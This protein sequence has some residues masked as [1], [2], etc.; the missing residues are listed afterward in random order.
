MWQTI[1]DFLGPVPAP[2]FILIFVAGLCVSLIACAPTQFV[3]RGER[4][5]RRLL[6]R[7]RNVKNARQ[8]TV[9]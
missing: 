4:V 7:R 9:F 2:I 8:N 5:V 1:Q 3:A 6:E